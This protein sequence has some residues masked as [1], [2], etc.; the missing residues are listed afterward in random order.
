[1]MLTKDQTKE[2]DKIKEWLSYFKNERPELYYYVLNE[3][4]PLIK[5]I[6]IVKAPVKAGKRGMVEI[7]CL[8]DPES[9]HIYITALHRTADEKQRTEL[10]SYG[11]NVFSINN[12]AKKDK[13]IKYIDDKLKKGRTI[14]THLDELDFGCGNK[15]LLNDIYPLYL[16]LLFLS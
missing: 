11:L 8:L 16:L 15:Q 9:T 3:I 14:K 2:A 4:M 6:K 5:K 10:E 12:K 13:C 1:M 7:Y